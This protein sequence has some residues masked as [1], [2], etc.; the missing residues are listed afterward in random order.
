M[1][2]DRVTVAEGEC[3]VTCASAFGDSHPFGTT[4]LIHGSTYS[5]QRY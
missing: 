4:T 2:E 1:M 5:P 3:L